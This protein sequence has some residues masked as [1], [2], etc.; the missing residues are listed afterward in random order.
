MISADP[1]VQLFRDMIVRALEQEIAPHYQDWE[2]AGAMTRT[3]WRTLGEAGMLGINMPEEY[4][5]AG[6]GFEISQMAAEEIAR[7]GFG[8]LAS[9]VSRIFRTPASSLP[10]PRPGLPWRG[11]S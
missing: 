10:R 7:Q 4:G 8:G 6:A 9:G 1:D 11:P 2:D 5:G 3:V